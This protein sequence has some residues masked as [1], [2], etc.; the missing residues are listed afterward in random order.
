MPELVRLY[1]RQSLAGLAVGI[2]FSMALVIFNIANLRHLVTNVDGG[3]LGFALLSLFN[4]LVFAGVY[5]GITIMGMRDE[6]D[7]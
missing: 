6:K 2:A 1:I 3:W 7:E 4:G 5:F